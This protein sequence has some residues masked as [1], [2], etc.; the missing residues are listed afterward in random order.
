M[1]VKSALLTG[2]DGSFLLET[3]VGQPYMAVFRTI[4]LQHILN[5]VVSTGTL[6]TDGIIPECE[7]SLTIF[8]ADLLAGLQF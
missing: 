5:E 6:E 7:L 1:C 2:R 8:H 3:E 4:R